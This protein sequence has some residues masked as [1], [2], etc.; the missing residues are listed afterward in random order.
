MM[1]DRSSRKIP[2]WIWGLAGVVLLGIL[3]WAGSTLS[4]EGDENLIAALPT[5]TSTSTATATSTATPTQTATPTLT[6]TPTKSPSNTP[7][8]SPTATPSLTPSPT[9]TATPTISPYG[10]PY[11]Y[12]GGSII[13]TDPFQKDAVSRQAAND[14]ILRPL[15]IFSSFLLLLIWMIFF[16]KESISRFSR[17][18]PSHFPPILDNG[19]DGFS[20]T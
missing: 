4:G 5:A 11:G 13:W 18:M 1:S 20:G 3:I 8:A 6:A 14:R 2:I 19:H 17:S 10:A 16:V 9:S 12:G 15:A 7:T